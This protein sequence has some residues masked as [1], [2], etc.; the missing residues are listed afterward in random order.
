[1]PEYSGLPVCA[2][3]GSRPGPPAKST[4]QTKRKRGPHA[5]LVA[6]LA[7]AVESRSELQTTA[8]SSWPGLCSCPR[9][10][11]Q[12]LQWAHFE[13]LF[14]CSNKTSFMDG[15]NRRNQAY[16]PPSTAILTFTHELVTSRVPFLVSF[17]SIVTF[18]L[19]NPAVCR[20]RRCGV[21]SRSTGC[22]HS[23]QRLEDS[24]SIPARLLDPAGSVRRQEL[25]V[26]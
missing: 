26:A 25:S 7:C 11:L 12:K 14:F 16:V 18:C 17:C 8:S 6:G 22:M 4:L 10:L 1:M 23:L 19:G 2:A 9:S 21:A 24:S 3:L 13:T 20:P 15:S 5:L